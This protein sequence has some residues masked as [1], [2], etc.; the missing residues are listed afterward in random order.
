MKLRQRSR[1]NLERLEDRSNPSVTASVVNGSLVVV[2]DPAAASDVTITA[3]DT[4]AD[5]IADTFDV[6]DGGTAVGTF[7]NV[8]DAVILRLSNNDDKVA[9]DLAGLTSPGRIRAD[10]RNGANSLTI[11]NGTVGGRVVVFGGTGTDLV[12]LGGTAELTVNGDVR[13]NLD[14]ANDDVFELGAD[15]TVTGK[16]E[17]AF[18]NNVNLDAGSTVDKSVFILGGSGGNIVNID[19]TVHK[20]VLFDAAP[21]GSTDGST[22]N[23]TGTVD[24]CVVF[25]GSKQDDTL[26]VT[27]TIGKDLFA[28]LRQGDDIATIG[29]TVQGNLRVHGGM[30]DDDITLS[31]EVGGRT[32]ITA[33]D[34]D[35]TVTIAATAVL[36]GRA[37]IDLGH[38][39][40]TLILDD[41]A[42]FSTLR[43]KGGKGIDT[44]TGDATR[45]GLTLTGFG[46]SNGHGHDH[47]HDHNDD[48]D[49][50][51]D[52]HE[53]DDD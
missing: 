44:F 46:P 34:G 24:G 29:G 37:K 31:G 51:E 18:A 35:D 12:T 39:D 25:I 28:N 5:D 41:A 22:L 40:D 42:T 33:G 53:D 19:G 8:T 1:I 16:L 3:S 32:K 17:I 14:G 47:D 50:H 11:D 27:G 38:G 26:N 20:H 9:I 48:H 21:F 15:A 45:P 23:V 7:N 49:D 43:A 13:V 6:T 36:T 10:L 4:N 52:D 30:G 2:G